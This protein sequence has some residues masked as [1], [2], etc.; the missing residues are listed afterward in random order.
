MVQNK[1]TA[2]RHALIAFAAGVMIVGCA[3]ALADGWGTHAGDAR[4]TAVSDTA[5][6]SLEVIRW[7]TPVDLAPPPGTI[8]RH[9]GSPLVTPGNTVIVP[10]KTQTSFQVEARRAR[11]GALIWSQ[12]T[13]YILPPHN[14]LPSYTPTLAGNRVYFP[15]PGGTIH[16]RSNPDSGAQELSGQLAFY[17][18]ANYQSDPAAYNATVFVNTPITSDS[19]GTIY[20]GF[21]TSGTPPL[22]LVSGVARIDAAGNGAWVSA[23]TASG[24]DSNII[25]VP[26]QCAP[27]LSADGQTLYIVVGSSTSTGVSYLVGLDPATLAL[28]QSG[29][30]MMRVALKDPRNAQVN[31]ARVTDDSSSSPTVGPDGDVYYGILGNPNNGSRGWMLH[32]SADLSQT[33]IPGAFGWDHT[34]SI[35]PAAAVPSYSGNSSYLLFT[36]Y[37]NY[38][39]LD[40]GDGVNRIAVLDPNDTQVE[41]HASSNGLLVMKEVLTKA[42]VTPDPNHTAQFP[43]AVLEWCVNTGAVDPATGSVLVNSEDGKLYRW[44]LSSNTLSQA[45]VLNSGIG[46]AYTPTAIGPDGTVY[47]LNKAVL[48]AVGQNYSLFPSPAS[49]TTGGNLIIEFVE[50]SGSFATNWIGLYKVGDPDTHYRWWRYTGGA[51]SGA[52]SLTAPDTPGAYEFRMFSDN[53]YNKIATS[54]TVTVNADSPTVTLTPAPTNPAVGADLTISFTA[55]PGRPVNDWI[56]LYRI[57]DPDTSY[58]WYRYTEGG[59]SGSFTLTAPSSAGQYE[60]RY[61]LRG[62][63]VKIATSSVV[64]VSDNNPTV[65]LTPSPTSLLVGADLAINFTTSS[66]RPDDWIGLYRAGDP[67]TS[68]LWY[69]YTGGLTSGAFTLAAPGPAGSYEFRYFVRG[70]YTRIATS[71]AVTVNQAS[72]YSLS[73][74]PAS[75]TQGAGIT[76]TWTNQNPSP[77]R[78]WVGMYRVGAPAG[79]YLAWIYVGDQR[80]GSGSANFTAPSSPGPVEFRYFLDN[81]LTELARSN[82]VNVN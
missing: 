57:G 69:R 31:N 64:T 75:V 35:V 71:A 65:T 54:R 1:L 34:P 22:G 50:P 76:V 5:S 42:G 74:S 6:Q 78:D 24:N 26:H 66:N 68:Y 80:F 63:Y 62:E 13:D 52:F 45:V 2:G 59:T 12:T 38:A 56:G 9:Y 43:N 82:P 81:S 7:S 28:K 33:K 23:R 67:D 16:W 25:R 10:V 17:G 44:D 29:Q 20:F 4:H 39:G 27:A 30:G 41:S 47:A 61:F 3:I 18:M 36:K 40:G 8:L 51:T 53:G 19:N 79:D 70:G 46:Q 48:N 55:P 14:W 60:F 49:V 37:N 15:G 21:R 77:P 11:D 72:G 32:F 73:A 58:L